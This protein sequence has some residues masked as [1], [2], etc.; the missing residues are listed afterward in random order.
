MKQKSRTCEENT[1]VK[2]IDLQGQKGTVYNI[3]EALNTQKL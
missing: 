2:R 3:K 1:T